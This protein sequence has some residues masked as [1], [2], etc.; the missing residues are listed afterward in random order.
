MRKKNIS[1]PNIEKLIALISASN[2]LSD[3]VMEEVNKFSKTK[4]TSRKLG[5]KK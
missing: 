3:R 1:K 4:F 2:Y 5:Q